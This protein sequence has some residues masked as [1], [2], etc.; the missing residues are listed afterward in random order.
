MNRMAVPE[1]VKQAFQR[2]AQHNDRDGLQWARDIVAKRDRGE[3]VAQATL[4]MARQ[5]LGARPLSKGG[6]DA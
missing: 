4:D 2:L 3:H 6:A 1:A 5:A